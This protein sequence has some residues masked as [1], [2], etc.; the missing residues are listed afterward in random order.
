MTGAEARAFPDGSA[1]L[2]YA[3]P[4]TDD[5]PPRSMNP[6]QRFSRELAEAAAD[7]AAE[8]SEPASGPDTID[9]DDWLSR[10]G[11]VARLL[12]TARRKGSEPAES[13]G[14]RD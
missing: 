10:V 7:S 8:R 4:F 5:R 1:R 11:D 3:T 6:L 12:R 14:D 13:A 2:D 9:R